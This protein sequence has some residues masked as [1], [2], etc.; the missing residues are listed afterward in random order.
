MASKRASPS[1]S[2]QSIP[3]GGVGQGAEAWYYESRR[4]VE[5]IQ[6]QRDS[7][8]T[9]MHGPVIR[10]PWSKLMKSA[11]RCGWKVKRV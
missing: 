10:I 4:G 3:K 5:I 11:A 1:L 8:G 9:L 6:Q 2:P 7:R